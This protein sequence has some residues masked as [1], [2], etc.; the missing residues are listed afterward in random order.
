M[1]S[2]PFPAERVSAGR[3]LALPALISNDDDRI[4]W[5]MVDSGATGLVLKPEIFG[6]FLER[7]S[8]VRSQSRGYVLTANT[9]EA[10]ETDVYYLDQLTLFN[11]NNKRVSF[12]W[13]DVQTIPAELPAAFGD[14]D[15][16]IGWLP[17]IQSMSLDRALAVVELTWT[18]KQDEFFPP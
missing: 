5:L 12:G 17:Q 8:F 4:Y 11:K 10:H 6:R 16:V 13:L 2:Y 15:G 1:P 9:A 3:L 14:I 18:M 7:G